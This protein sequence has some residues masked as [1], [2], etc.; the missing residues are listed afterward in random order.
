MITLEQTTLNV[1]A[2]KGLF[3]IPINAFQFD[4]DKLNTIFVSTFHKYE[5]YCPRLKTLQNL[6]GNPVK[7]PDDCIY[8]RSIGFGNSSMIMP[9]TVAVGRQ[10]WSYDRQTKM[11]SVFTN[12]GSSAQL[13]VQYLA[14]HDHIL[15]PVSIEPTE[16]FDGE[17]EVEIQLETV[18][19]PST[20]KVTKGDSELHITSRT[21]ECWTLEGTLGTAEFNLTELTL[22][23]T[24]T[25]TSAGFINIEYE[26]KYKAFDFMTDDLDFF[27][28]WYAANILSSL[29]AIKAILKM[30]QLPNDINADSLLSEGR[31]LYEDV[32]RWQEAEKTF[33]WMG[34]PSART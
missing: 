25:D 30:D 9:Q 7:M 24:Q 32:K 15:A 28:T 34:Y 27:E 12:T 4:W 23:I 21:R 31:S 10:D 26:N 20:F 3:A 11:L 29:G 13:K 5:R 19:N 2:T 22:N 18:P 14:R 33:W 8:P 1:I 17:T 6:G 16:V